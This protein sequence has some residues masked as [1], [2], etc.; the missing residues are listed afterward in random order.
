VN[1]SR[2]RETPLPLY[3][4]LK[5]HGLTRKRT[6]VDVFFN[7]GMCVSYDRLLQVTADMASGICTQFEAD[8]V[9]CP[10]NM[11]HGLFTT[12]AI[13]NVDHNPSS[14]T[15]RDSFHGTSISIMQHLTH[16]SSGTKRDTVVI[17]QEI[18]SAKSV[19][20][21]PTSYT[22]VPQAALEK[23]QFTVPV[24]FGP[25]KPTD[26]QHVDKAA[27]QEATWLN[28]VMEALQKE[29]LEIGDW[30]SWSA[31]HAH[32]QQTIIPP[33]AINAMLP[34]FLDNAHSVAMIKHSMDMIRAAVQLLN[35]GQ[36]PVIA[37]D[38]PLYAMAKRIQWTWPITHG[39][40][41]FVVMFGG[42]HIEMAILKVLGNWL[43]DSGWTSALTQAN[44]ASS[45]TADSFI[46]ASHVTKTRH[47]HQVTVASLHTLLSEAYTKKCGEEAT[48]SFDEWCT[49]RAAQSVHFDYWFKVMS[50]EIM[51]LLYVRSIREGDFDLYVQSL[52]QLMPWFFAL[53]H[54]HYSRW[55]SVHIRDMMILSE[56][57][58][59]ILEAFRS[60]Q[61][62]V[63]KTSNKFS[64]M[65]IDQCHE[66]NNAVIKGSGGAVGLT[67]NPAA[68]RRWTVAGPEV[69]RL[70]TE[71]EDDT[72][73]YTRRDRPASEN[74]HHDQQP[75]VQSAFLKDVRAL[76][77]VIQDLG[78][79]FLEESNDLLVLDTKC[80]MDD[81]VAD[82]VRKVTTLGEDQYSKFVEERLS[83]CSKPV[84]DVLKKNKLPLL[85]RSTVK[86]APSKGKLQLQAMK[87]DCNLFSRLYLACQA[88]DGDVDQFFCHENNL[89]PP[90]LSLGGKLRLGTKADLMPCL[91][92]DVVAP[93]DSPVVDAKFL[94]E[95]AIVQMLNPGTAKT[96]Q[97]YADQVFVPHVSTQ[98]ANT[99]RIDIVWDVY[100]SDSL[101][102]TT[103]NKRGKGI[104]RRVVPA[105]AMPK[106]WKDFLRVDENKT[107]LFS[108]LSGQIILA[109]IEDK[110]VYATEG[111]HVLCSFDRP[112]MS[113]L[114]PCSHEEAD[115]RLLL[116]AADAVKEGYKKLLVRTVD[117][118]VVVVAVAT[119]SSIHP[120]ELWLAFGTGPNFRYIPVHPI[121]SSLGP[122]KSVC[123]PIFHALT[124]CDTVSSM[125]GIGKKT[126]WSTWNAYPDVTE[127]FEELAHMPGD[128]SSK[129]MES[130]ERFVVLLYSRTSE[131]NRVKDARKT[132]FARKSRLLENI[133]PT[134]AALRQHIKRACYQSH[135][136]NMSL[137]TD[138]QL[139]NPAD[140]GWTKVQDEWQPLWSTLP[141]AAK[142][143]YELIHCGFTKGCSGRCKC[144]KAALKCTTLCACSGDCRN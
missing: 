140:W 102:S 108:F 116:H 128:I 141:E 85:S 26:R 49:D 46:C 139:P 50:L 29:K 71:F 38:Q 66:Q 101:K 4:A 136:W 119:L 76:T 12:G 143:C 68:L 58:P 114:E 120:D 121:A 81:I 106:N 131:L 2:D 27:K 39:E 144:A 60:G 20:P 37:A 51:L 117:T 28:T 65:A 110:E 75:G 130:L 92:T 23:K 124:G 74:R 45:G 79:P 122:R 138:P 69:I 22:S 21:L 127:A 11:R 18:A 84:T 30:I 42:L 61:F 13:D 70:I 98:L 80:I 5:M 3:I 109:E 56:K 57:H 100:Q 63:N 16:E 129:S 86:T 48:T 44:I 59:D 62:E 6:L 91:E 96:F 83:K 125:A 107:E 99:R 87:S 41:S 8:K 9:V 77:A 126:A 19:P 32:L 64:A 97:E 137:S 33:A 142:S 34:L 73:S 135:C 123:L 31:Y 52:A 103:R 7:L 105:A 88:R 93:A 72:E 112:D 43:E 24:V 17:N 111:Q 115:T 90:S 54:I 89:C 78:N 15:A 118:D 40:D 134:Q 47:A 55:L 113:D 36:I 82:T 104:R 1:H 25:V 67:D 35:P 132:L 94:D 10:P 53:D 14:A 95:A 133:P